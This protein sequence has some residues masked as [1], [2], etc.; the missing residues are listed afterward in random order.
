MIISFRTCCRLYDEWIILFETYVI[1][2]ADE[3]HHHSVLRKKSLKLYRRSHWPLPNNQLSVEE[4]KRIVVYST[5][6]TLL[7]K[8]PAGTYVSKASTARQYTANKGIFIHIFTAYINIY[9]TVAG[10]MF[11]VLTKFP[12]QCSC[13]IFY[14]PNSMFMDLGRLFKVIT[15]QEVSKWFVL[16]CASLC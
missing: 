13:H 12:W 2:W 11:F 16:C 1:S 6:Q 5:H 9:G 14:K 15:S 7:D 3:I 8:W 4:C 10:M